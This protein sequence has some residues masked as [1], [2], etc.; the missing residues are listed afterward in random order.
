MVLAHH[1]V[2]TAYGWWLPNDPRGSMSRYI[3]SD[4]IADLGELHY[5]RKRVQP[6]S[7]II[8]A[9]YDQAKQVLKFPLLRFDPVELPAI[10]DAFSSVISE[11]RYTCY[12]CAIMPDHVHIL[13]R[14]HRDH[15]EN[16]IDKLQTASRA[17]V[18]DAGMRSTDH[19][20][21]GGDGWRVF[22]DSPDDIRRTVQY[23]EQNPIKA[24]M[25]RQTWGFVVPYDNWPFHKC[26]G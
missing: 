8:R 14:K 15:A 4:V 12:A 6:A 17:R 19:P 3:A 20:V 5:G 26:K 16:M 23:I 25:P 9:F 7:R 2:W 11:N 13:L 18:I 24:R 10:A 1:L 21:W 22:L